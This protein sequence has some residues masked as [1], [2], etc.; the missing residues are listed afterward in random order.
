MPTVYKE[1]FSLV[2]DHPPR[3][4]H[5][6]KI[7]STLG[8]YYMYAI[9]P[10]EYYIIVLLPSS[11]WPFLPT[12]SSTPIIPFPLFS[13]V[14]PAECALVLA[15]VLP[16]DYTFFFSLLYFFAFDASLIKA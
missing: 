13:L 11:S 10:A 15:I 5:Q 12:H 3:V 4:S 16:L 9:L 6:S 1:L 7:L 14:T 8:H 2:D